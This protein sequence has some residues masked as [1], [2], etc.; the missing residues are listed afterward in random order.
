MINQ[1]KRK[2]LPLILAGGI[3]LGIL[4]FGRLREGKF[5][6]DEARVREVGEYMN[7]I[8]GVDGVRIYQ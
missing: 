1:L 6:I 7:K 8:R 4:N 3:P 5:E 2:L